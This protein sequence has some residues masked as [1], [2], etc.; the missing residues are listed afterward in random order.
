MEK[1]YRLLDLKSAIAMFCFFQDRLGERFMFRKRFSS[2]KLVFFK[3]RNSGY[4]T[5]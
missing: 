5:K 2:S 1:L 3:P 4:V